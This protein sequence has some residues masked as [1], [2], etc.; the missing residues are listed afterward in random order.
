M[1]LGIVVVLV[2]EAVG[3]LLCILHFFP[4]T[5][6]DGIIIVHIEFA[7]CVIVFFRQKFRERTHIRRLFVPVLLF[8][9]GMPCLVHPEVITSIFAGP[10]AGDLALVIY[11]HKGDRYVI[12]F[13]APC[14]HNAASTHIICEVAFTFVDG[15]NR[16]KIS[17]KL[18]A[19]LLYELQTIDDLIPA[20]ICLVIVFRN[21]DRI[22]S[23][24]AAQPFRIT[25]GKDTTKQA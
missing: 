23:Q 22:I 2:E 19:I 21:V 11:L 17:K 25:A 14:D 6:F 5:L 24:C 12:V 1:V 7:G 20:V 18:I 16:S 4:V 15:G 8:L 13:F 9:C 3:F 10:N